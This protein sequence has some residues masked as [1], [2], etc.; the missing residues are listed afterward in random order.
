M[1][2]S[3]LEEARKA[4]KSPAALK[5]KLSQYRSRFQETPILILEGIDDIGP[6]ETWIN[7]ITNRSRLKL[8]SGNGK[9]QLL[10]LRSLLEKDETGLRD[11]VFFVVDRDFD[12]LSGQT[13]GKDI[14]C[15]DRYSVESYVIG[16]E[17][18][19]SLL[20]DE[21]RLEEGSPEFQNAME[22]YDN[23]LQ[24]LINAINCINLRIY[25]C[26]LSGVRFL[27]Q[28]PEVRK[29]VKIH[30]DKIDVIFC[31]KVI[32]SE[33]EIASPLD[34]RAVELLRMDF[35]KLNPKLRHRGKFF[36]QFLVT[37][38][39]KLSDEARNPTGVIFQKKLGIK[40]SS[41][42][43]TLRSLASRSELPIGLQEYIKGI[44]GE[45]S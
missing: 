41:S 2:I 15:T 22:V 40:F 36:F 29:F 42:S 31:D 20:R 30:L 18:V 17:V 43:I 21:F 14:F 32:E 9:G 4:R 24:Q 12:D 37:W 10:G 23:V 6:Y 19:A 3:L 33:L 44:D 39:E 34:E 16:K 7:R 13:P 27:K 38:I 28:I 8:L 45:P 26:R 1:T 35:D 5:I 11:S 25:C